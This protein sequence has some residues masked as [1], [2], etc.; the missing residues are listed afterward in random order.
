MSFV[1]DRASDTLMAVYRINPMVSFTDI[2][3]ALMYDQHL[4]NAGDVAWVIV[5]ST[6][7]LLVG[8]RIF[9]HFEPRLAEEL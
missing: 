1:E 6:A 2:Y 5:A 9:K 3:R 7:M 4:P 8:Y